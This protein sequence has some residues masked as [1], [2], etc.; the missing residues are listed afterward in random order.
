MM[1]WSMF[2][3]IVLRYIIIININVSNSRLFSSIINKSLSKSL[4]N[5]NWIK[6][7]SKFICFPLAFLFPCL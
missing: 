6:Y 1:K 3:F 2:C 4:Y 5:M 7:T